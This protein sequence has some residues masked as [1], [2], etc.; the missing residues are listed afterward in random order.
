MK[1]LRRPSLRDVTGNECQWTREA[2]SRG[3]FSL[4]PLACTSRILPSPSP[5]ATCTLSPKAA[6]AAT[7]FSLSNLYFRQYLRKED[8]SPNFSQVQFNF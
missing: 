6:I 3:C 4:S 1:C 8:S 7:P 2:T 5:S